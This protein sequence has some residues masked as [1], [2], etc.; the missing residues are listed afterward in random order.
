MASAPTG[1]PLAPEVNS[2][3]IRQRSHKIHGTA[4]QYLSRKGSTRILGQGHMFPTVRSRHWPS[5]FAT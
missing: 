5:S 2:L 4:V 3:R 1:P